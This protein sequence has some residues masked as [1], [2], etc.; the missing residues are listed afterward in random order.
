[1]GIAEIQQEI[2]S[3]PPDEQTALLNWLAERDRLCWDA[4]IESDFSEGGRGVELLSHVK[5]QIRRG[6][7]KPLTLRPKP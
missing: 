3:L 2:E 4:E 1:V 6:E 7:S 5:E